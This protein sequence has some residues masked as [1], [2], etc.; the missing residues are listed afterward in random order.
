M[1]SGSR[2]GIS[3]NWLYNAWQSF[4]E[5]AEEVANLL[6]AALGELLVS[7]NHLN[8]IFRAIAL[9]GVSHFLLLP[10]HLQSFLQGLAGSLRVLEVQ[11]P[12]LDGLHGYPAG[13]SAVIPQV[14]LVVVHDGSELFFLGLVEDDVHG[15]EDVLLHPLRVG[16]RRVNFVHVVVALPH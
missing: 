14:A 12:H 13:Q 3:I 10:L 1:H 15:L 9:L 7:L 2:A 16:Q 4:V 8:W 11:P 6:E 5:G